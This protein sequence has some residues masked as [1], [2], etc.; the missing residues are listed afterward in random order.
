MKFRAKCDY[1]RERRLLTSPVTISLE[2]TTGK[3]TT[4]N[5]TKLEPIVD[6]EHLLIQEMHSLENKTS[7][8]TDSAAKNQEA[9]ERLPAIFS[10]VKTLIKNYYQQTQNHVIYEICITAFAIILFIAYRM[11]KTK[12]ERRRNNN[13]KKRARSK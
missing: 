5:Q 6:E 3:T 2:F 4:L 12:K 10:H 11:S 13:R 8:M 7:N 1:A 9:N